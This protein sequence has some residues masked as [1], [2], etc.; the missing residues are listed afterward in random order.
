MIRFPVSDEGENYTFD[1]VV[2]KKEQLKTDC[3][4]IKTIRIE[5]KLFGKDQIFGREGTMTMWL[6]DNKQHIPVRMIA[7]TGGNTLS[8]RLLN[9]KTNCQIAEA[10][11]EELR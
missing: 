11:Q 8:G 10:E 2:G 5:P 7:R 3:G 6:T 9:F 4:K 1:V